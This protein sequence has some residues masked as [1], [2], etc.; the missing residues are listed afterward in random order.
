MA[1]GYKRGDVLIPMLN[2][3]AGE[4]PGLQRQGQEFVLKQ[5][6]L[7]LDNRKLNVV[8][9]QQKYQNEQAKEQQELAQKNMIEQRTF[10]DKQAKKFIRKKL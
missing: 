8:E 7:A 2:E 5:S 9:E 4:L 1:N 3:I 6:S 10:R